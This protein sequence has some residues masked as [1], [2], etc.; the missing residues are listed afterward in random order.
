MSIFDLKYQK[1]SYIR[2]ISEI[3]VIASHLKFCPKTLKPPRTDP[4][5]QNQ[6]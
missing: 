3:F 1:R 4:T 6:D 5:F 2:Y